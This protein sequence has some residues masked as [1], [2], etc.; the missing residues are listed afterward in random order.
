MGDV[1]EAYGTKGVFKG[2]VQVEAAVST[3]ITITAEEVELSA[4]ELITADQLETNIGKTV[5]IENI[6]VMTEAGHGE[7]NAQDDAQ[8]D[9]IIDNEF[10]GS[11]V[12][13]NT[14]L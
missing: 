9:L 1:I 10:I 6:K 4:P 5:T 2:N 12:S 14:Q 11:S 13:M 7:F 3:D 8:T